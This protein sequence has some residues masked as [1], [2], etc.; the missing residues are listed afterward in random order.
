MKPRQ[1]LDIRRC[2]CYTLVNNEEGSQ[3]FVV[4]IVKEKRMLHQRLKHVLVSYDTSNLEVGECVL[5]NSPVVREDFERYSKSYDVPIKFEAVTPIDD[6]DDMDGLQE[7]A[8][9]LVR[10]NAK[11][12][13]KRTQHPDIVY[14]PSE[15]GI[16][17]VIDIAETLYNLSM[18]SVWTKEQ[19]L[20]MCLES[21]KESSMLPKIL[22]DEH[23]GEPYNKSVA[24]RIKRA[25]VFNYKPV[26]EQLFHNP[27]PLS[28]SVNVQDRYRQSL[29]D[30]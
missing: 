14:K 22:W 19:L 23:G 9:N 6:E 26:E 29:G 16:R 30:V 3:Q 25:S 28:N 20:E 15:D 1:P 17:E 5:L 27:L 24:Y 13:K 21:T 2:L 7:W 4:I 10:E 12:S 11:E 18:E 8:E